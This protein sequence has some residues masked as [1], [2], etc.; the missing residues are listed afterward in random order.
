MLKKLILKTAMYGVVMFGLSTYAGYL[1]T[2]HM[3]AY[4]AHLKS[5]LAEPGS[6]SHVQ[7]SWSDIGRLEH[8]A[9]SA[10][11]GY[12]IMQ[13][14]RTVIYKWQDS[15]GHWQYGE[16]APSNN[17]ATKIEIATSPVTS[18]SPGEPTDAET[19]TQERIDR[20]AL[21]NPYSPEGV[22]QIMDKAHEVQRAMNRHN[23]ELGR[24]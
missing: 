10:S 18:S 24:D 22:K 20:S 13:G 15:Q 16:R 21:I 19:Q 11:E 17:I 6:P 8:T 7:P 3:P 4:M 12:E 14:G 5:L 2:G 23:E 1:M 9:K